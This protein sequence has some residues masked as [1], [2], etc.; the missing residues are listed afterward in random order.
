[1]I[2][3][4]FLPYDSCDD[5][6]PRRP[7]SFGSW[8]KYLRP[9]ALRHAPHDDIARYERVFI[10]L[11][12]R[13]GEKMEFFDVENAPPRTVRPRN[14]LNYTEF[15]DEIEKTYLRRKLRSLS[16]QNMRPS[17]R[18]SRR[19]TT[20]PEAS[21]TDV[22]RRMQVTPRRDTP[23]ELAV[24]SAVHA[25]GLRFRVDWPLPGT[26]RRADLAFV[27]PKVAVFVD[28]CFWHGCPEHATWP[29]ANAIWWREKI[30]TNIRRDRDTD[31]LLRAIGWTVLRFWEHDEATQAA[32]AIRHTLRAGRGRAA[33]RA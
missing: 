5:A 12:D 10:G 9:L 21:S 26:R 1:M 11:Y 24:R 6:S 27:G 13:A 19:P 17:R 8:V 18:M 20:R 25:M 2:A 15:L 22:R 29:K 28:G 32:R 30:E 23:C 7:S 4:V 31:A 16:G 14:L 3:V 33:G